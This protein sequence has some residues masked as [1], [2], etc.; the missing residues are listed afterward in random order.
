MRHPP[1]RGARM[2][3][4]EGSLGSKVTRVK[5]LVFPRAGQPLLFT[6][7]KGVTLENDTYENTAIATAR[8]VKSR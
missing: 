7:G 8:W 4:H 1:F 6:T 2:T 3:A 5:S